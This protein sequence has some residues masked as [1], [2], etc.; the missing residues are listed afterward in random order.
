MFPW[1]W[2]HPIIHFPYSGDVVQD[3]A[4]STVW[5]LP[6]SGPY[7]GNKA[8]ERKILADGAGYGEQLKLI[9]EA[10]AEILAALPSNK[11]G[12]ACG[13]LKALQTQI[14]TVKDAYYTDAATHVRD[15]LEAL[16]KTDEK[17]YEQLVRELVG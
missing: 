8:L 5:D 7:K 9:H 13:K 1:F 14:N 6:F 12:D 10:L 3:I 2:Y 15:A 11:Q 4:P 17:A 16:R